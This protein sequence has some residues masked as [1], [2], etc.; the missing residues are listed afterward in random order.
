MDERCGRPE[1][2][3][4]LV[5]TIAGI[6]IIT[7]CGLPCASG[8]S[9]R[10][11]E[12][13]SVKLNHSGDLSSGEHTGRGRLTVT[14]D[15]LK[16]LIRFAFDVWDFQIEG[17]P[18][19]LDADRFDIV[20]TT[21]SSD[22]ITNQQLRRLL[23]ALLADRFQ[24]KAHRETKEMTVYSLVVTKNG[25][26]LTE[27][28]GDG[29]GDSSTNAS[30]GNIRATRATM[31]TLANSLSGVMGR[32]VIDNTRLRGTFDYKLVWAPEQADSTA[33]SIFTAVQEQL[34]LRLESAKG[35]IEMLLI[36]GA[37]KPSEN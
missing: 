27:H 4:A 2:A 28:T 22:V 18:R 34:G 33:P 26:K 20:A 23:Q 14:N 37:E 12:V 17:G 5:R 13:A 35:P 29:G 16:Q 1:P 21:G 19:W 11:F 24:L 8:Q 9:A 7:T 15:T 3:R 6:L 31:A 36:D 25:P 30:T 10:E 32:P